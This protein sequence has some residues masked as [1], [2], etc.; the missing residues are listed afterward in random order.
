MLWKSSHP[1]A[2]N[3]FKHLFLLS[4]APGRPRSPRKPSNY[5]IW[6]WQRRK[7]VP[8]AIGVHPADVIFPQARNSA[9]RWGLRKQKLRCVKMTPFGRPVV[10]EVVKMTAG[11]SGP[12]RFLVHGSQDVPNPRQLSVISSG[13]AFFRTIKC[14]MAGI[15]SLIFSIPGR[16]D[17]CRIKASAP[18]SSRILSYCTGS[19][20]LGLILDDAYAFLPLNIVKQPITVWVPLGHWD[21]GDSVAWVQ[22]A[23]F[24]VRW[25]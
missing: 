16:K 15:S 8:K 3:G 18:E 6:D 24:L 22:F 11:S 25:P 9:Q 7:R 23:F 2:F 5:R 10:L 21:I 14:F 12:N 17:S 19:A 1:M 4:F 20:R 13:S